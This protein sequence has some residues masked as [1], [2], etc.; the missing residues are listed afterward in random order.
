METIRPIPTT[1]RLINIDLIFPVSTAVL[2]SSYLA[3][4]HICI[5]TKK[6]SNMGPPCSHARTPQ[7]SNLYRPN[8]GSLGS[9]TPPPYLVLSTTDFVVLVLENSISTFVFDVQKGWNVWD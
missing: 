6:E 1:E 2:N 4:L 9:E 3:F 7:L 5:H 8:F